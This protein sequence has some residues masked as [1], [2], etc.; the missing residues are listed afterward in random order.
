MEIH[1]TPPLEELVKKEA[2]RCGALAWA[3]EASQRWTANWNTRLMFPSI[4]LGTLAGVGSVGA[5][6]ILP[7]SGAA[8]LTGL[9]TIGVSILQ[10][11]NSRLDFAKRSEAHRFAHLHYSKLNAGLCLQLSLP[12]TERKLAREVIEWI[13]D[14]TGRLAEIVPLIPMNIKEEFHKRFGQF[15]D[16]AIPSILNG[17]ERVKITQTEEAQVR[18]VVRITI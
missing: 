3:H 17:L 7:F 8:T 2:E 11:I 5:E 14:E 18:P 16:Y 4:I 1:W 9:M 12:R 10:M 13:E 6:S 15:E